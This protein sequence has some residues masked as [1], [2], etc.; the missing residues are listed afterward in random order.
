MRSQSCNM[1]ATLGSAVANPTWSNLMS[2]V[3]PVRSRRFLRS[4]IPHVLAVVALSMS[5]CQGDS[6]GPIVQDPPGRI[7]FQSIPGGNFNTGDV[8]IINGDGTGFARLTSD[9]A[10]HFDPIL[11]PDGA[12]VAYRSGNDGNLHVM[13]SDGSNDRDLG[14]SGR[15][16]DFSPDGQRILF[17]DGA[18]QMWVVDVDGSNATMLGVGGNQAAWSPNGQR[19]AF[20]LAGAIWVMDADGTDVVALLP[21]PGVEGFF[22]PRWSPDGSRIAFESF[23]GDLDVGYIEVMNA[24]GSGRQ[25]LTSGQVK[26]YLPDWS[27]DGEWIVFERFDGA[28]YDLHVMRSDGTSVEVLRSDA[29]TAKWGR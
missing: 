19:I 2:P 26:D 16:P 14:L 6:A 1:R 24:N 25:A 21:A 7:V 13:N 22:S 11:S 18:G 28:S 20:T 17:R 9:G 23:D 10:G 27:P 4:S 8:A 5:A 15:F 3:E 12:L 29:S